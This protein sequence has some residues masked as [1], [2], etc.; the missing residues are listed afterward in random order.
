[1]PPLYVSSYALLHTGLAGRPKVLLNIDIVELLR[2]YRNDWGQIADALQIRTA[3]WQY[4]KEAG[5]L[6]QK[7]IDDELYSVMSQIQRKHPNCDQQLLC[8]FLKDKG[9]F[10]K[11]YRLR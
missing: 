3:L 6:I 10:V 1:M 8:E 9:V 7:Y 4:I 5:C 11:W 2:S